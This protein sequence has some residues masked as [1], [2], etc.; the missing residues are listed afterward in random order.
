MN[1]ARTVSKSPFPISRWRS[2]LLMEEVSTVLSVLCFVRLF[3]GLTLKSPSKLYSACNVWISSPS[4]S[5]HFACDNIKTVTAVTAL[6]VNVQVL[7]RRIAFSP[8]ILPEKARPRSFVHGVASILREKPTSPAV[9]I[10]KSRP[11]S[12]CTTMLALQKR[13]MVVSVCAY[14]SKNR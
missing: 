8:Q 11:I 4:S 13:S 1:S 9:R 6:T 7:G 3:T 12:P 14:I 2:H 5:W 10:C